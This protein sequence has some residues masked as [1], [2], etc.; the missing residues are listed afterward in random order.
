MIVLFY[1]PDAGRTKRRARETLSRDGL[2]LTA[3]YD[4]FQDRLSD[5]LLD[6]SSLSLFG[7]RKRVLVENAFFLSTVKPPRG[8]QKEDEKELRSFLSLLPEADEFD[9]F[10]LL[11]G[12]LDAKSD[13]VKSLR[14]QKS[15]RFEEVPT[16]SRDDCFGLAQRRA[17]ENGGTIENE[18]IELLVERCG[19]DFLLLDNTL[20]LLF[21]HGK[22]VTAKDVS[23]LVAENPE[24]KAY[25]VLSHLLR[26]ALSESLQCYRNVRRQGMEGVS[27]LSSLVSQLRLMALVQGLAEEG[28]DNEEIARELS[29]LSSPVKPGRVYYVRKDLR[30]LSFSALLSVLSDLSVLEEQVKLEGD[31]VDTRLECFFLS[32]DRRYRSQRS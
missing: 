17:K 30:G 25:E 19:K 11:P 31:D 8:A 32:F 23:A 16:L 1:G 2:E 9:L 13:V 10:L 15:V 5:V 24:D 7:E 22:E 18:A 4:L 14:K 12:P 20:S 28:K 26:G 27:V 29:S 3:S 21:L 6:L